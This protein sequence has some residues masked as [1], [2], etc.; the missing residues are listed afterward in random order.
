MEYYSFYFKNIILLFTVSYMCMTVFICFHL[1]I[2]H[3]CSFPFPFEMFF[4]TTSS[5]I[6]MSFLDNKMNF[7][8]AAYR[9]SGKKLFKGA[10]VLTIG[11][12]IGRMSSPTT[13]VNYYR[14]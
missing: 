3:S 11:Y 14:Y 13:T 10:W 7:V 2:S 1:N 5:S 8:R 12:T 9:S 4:S 6:F